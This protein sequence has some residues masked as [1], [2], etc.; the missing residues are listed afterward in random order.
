MNKKIILFLITVLC[1]VSIP[2]FGADSSVDDVIKGALKDD[3]FVE[4]KKVRFKFKGEFK[5]LFTMVYADQYLKTMISPPE[6][7][8]L[9]TDMK[10]L[11]LS[12][13][14]LVSNILTLHVDY[15]NEIYTGSFNNSITFKNYWT[16]SQYNDFV[17]MYWDLAETD[18]ILYRMK[19]LNAY[20]KIV[21][22]PVTMT[23]GQQQ[24]RFGS[25][26]LWNPLDILASITPTAI[27][28]PEEQKGILAFRSDFYFN[29]STELS[30]V[31]SQNRN[32]N[33]F[34]SV[35]I[36]DSN[37]VLRFKTTVW[38]FDFSILGGWVARRITAGG[39][40]SLTLFDGILRAAS[41]YFRPEDGKQYVQVNAGYEYTIKKGPT[42][43]LEYFYNSASINSNSQLST[44]LMSYS[45]GTMKQTDFNN[46]AA[47]VLTMNSH[48]LAIG[49]SWEFAA[50]WNSNLMFIYDVE[51][52]GI[53]VTLSVQYNILENLDLS[54]GIMYAQ[55]VDRK[56]Y[57][58]DFDAFHQKPFGY[59]VF[60]FTF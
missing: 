9:I 12:G 7:K 19:L 10:R 4:D 53:F 32:E 16:P 54:L 56:D 48:Y 33:N 17:P 58:S 18:D 49:G 38:K 6:K 37:G 51:G 2:L 47:R 46:I 5:D 30:F 36:A 50:L 59:F 25:G 15:D 41:A 14:L 21:L 1:V 3:D 20:A 28:G 42:L 13:N 55:V 8:L 39:D 57:P 44:S 22:G 34:D 35:T 26:K 31:Y 60:D 45:A 24:V 52:Q 27:E 11:R 29:D 40:V 43:Y 23:I